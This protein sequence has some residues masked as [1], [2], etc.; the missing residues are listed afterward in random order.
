LLEEAIEKITLKL[1]E[2]AVTTNATFTTCI[3]PE[4]LKKQKKEIENLR[5][6]MTELTKVYQ[7]FR[8]DTNSL[9]DTMREK[10][11]NLNISQDSSISLIQS[12]NDKVNMDRIRMTEAKESTRNAATAITA[13]LEELQ[14]TIDQIKLDVTQRRCRPSK[15]Q[16]KHCEEESTILGQEM[17]DLSG[18]I[19][20][21]KPTWKKTWETELQDIVNEQQFLKDQEAL[22]VDL[23]EDH[24]ALLEVLDQL[25]KISEIQERK[26]Q[27]HGVEFRRA[28]IEEGFD[29]MTSVIKQV[30]NIHVDHNRRVKAMVQ[31]EKMRALELSQRIDAFE[32]E[33]SDF[34]GC[35]KLKKIGGAEAIEKQRQEKDQALIKQI[36]DK[37]ENNDEAQQ[38]E[39]TKLNDGENIEND[40]G[41]SVG[42]E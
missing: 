29:G 11:K 6:E 32:E 34:V 40:T 39:K 8:G 31:A 23:K 3:P 5:F 16:L 21:F 1:Q 33:L 27:Y 15:A 26:Q 14:D 12:K 13:R 20:A 28:P 36:F 35:N 17:D 9:I 18:K 30:S 38:Q 25:A 10:S 19:K 22:L 2:N 37:G 41:S 7:D 4:A 24:N 42:I